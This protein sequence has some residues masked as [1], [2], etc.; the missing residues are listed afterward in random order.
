MDRNNV[1]NATGLPAANAQAAAAAAAAGAGAGHDAGILI[2]GMSMSSRM[3]I[4][5]VPL[6]ISGAGYAG[7]F[8]A[9]PAR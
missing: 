3:L 5:M 8:F 4:I 9:D 1:S 2:F 7:A 6:M